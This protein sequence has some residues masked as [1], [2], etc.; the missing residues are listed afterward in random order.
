MWLKFKDSQR[1]SL[2]WC[3]ENFSEKV[4]LRKRLFMFFLTAHERRATKMAVGGEKLRE[5]L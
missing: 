2:K 3:G 4:K 5:Q 1:Q